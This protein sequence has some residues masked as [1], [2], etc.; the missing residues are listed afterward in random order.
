[1][2]N[3]DDR[4]NKDMS[5]EDILASIRKYVAEDDINKASSESKDD[6][7]VVKNEYD[8]D[9]TVIKLDESQIISEDSKEIPTTIN[10]DSTYSPTSSNPATYTEVSSLSASVVNVPNSENKRSDNPFNKLATALKAYGRPHETPAKSPRKESLTI[11]KFLEN[12]A[13]PL[14]EKWI[15]DNLNQIVEQAVDREIQKLKT[16]D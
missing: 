13:T 8:S 10:S 12:I 9:Q 7:N 2:T 6:K 3:F 1:M 15:N 11:D 16:D 5:M 14:I 4:D